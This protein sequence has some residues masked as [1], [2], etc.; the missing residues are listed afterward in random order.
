MKACIGRARRDREDD[1]P[2]QNVGFHE[3]PKHTLLLLRFQTIHEIINRL[4]VWILTGK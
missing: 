3:Q 2:W 4:R 1:G